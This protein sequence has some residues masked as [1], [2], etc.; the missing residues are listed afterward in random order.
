M[1]DNDRDTPQYNSIASQIVRGLDNG[2]QAAGAVLNKMTLGKGKAGAAFMAAGLVA[3]SL[4]TGFVAYVTQPD[5][6]G[7]VT[8]AGID[9]DIT[10]RGLMNQ[11]YSFVPH[12]ETFFMLIR[13][14]D[15]TELYQWNNERSRIELV[16][17][18]GLA[19]RIVE[20]IARRYRQQIDGFNLDAGARYSS[21]FYTCPTIENPFITSDGA[22]TRWYSGCEKLSDKSVGQITQAYEETQAFWQ[23]T[24]AQMSAEK[25]GPTGDIPRYAAPDRSGRESFVEKTTDAAL[26]L[27]ALWAGYGVAGAG[28]SG[29]R[30]RATAPKK[31]R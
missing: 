19:S 22:S 7:G 17:D 29:L 21:D 25:Y 2:G 26:L 13:D 4:G 8:S 6:V 31:R 28:V 20:E 9:Y 14:Q 1:A 3:G 16:H 11:T 12:R 10:G 23:S 24:L 27:L 18:F 5:P 30:Q 15:R